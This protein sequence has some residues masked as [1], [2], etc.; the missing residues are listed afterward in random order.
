MK[1]DYMVLS[2]AAMAIV[3]G[4]IGFVASNIASNKNDL[5]EAQYAAVQPC[6]L[7]TLAEAKEVI[8]ESAALAQD[9]KPQTNGDMQIETCSYGVQSAGTTTIASL[10]VRSALTDSGTQSNQRGFDQNMTDTMEMVEGYGDHAYWDAEKAQLNIHQG[11][12]WMIV[13]NGTPD[14]SAATL[15][16]AKLVAD[17]VV[18][19]E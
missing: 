1:K 19:K 4:V 8:G 7:F 10:T 9:G 14:P 6:E 17:K 18:N 11:R 16:N 15:D 2:F 5:P 13:T 12:N 3:L